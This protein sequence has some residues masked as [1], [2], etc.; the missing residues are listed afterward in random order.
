[1]SSLSC[2]Y[3]P[4]S[5][6]SCGKESQSFEVGCAG[7]KAFLFLFEKAQDFVEENFRKKG[8]L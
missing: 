1:L 2:H 5:F 4:S 7:E 8:D 3:C 6:Y